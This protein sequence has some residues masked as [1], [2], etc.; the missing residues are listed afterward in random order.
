MPLFWDPICPPQ[1]I[2]SLKSYLDKRDYE[3][4]IVDFNTDGTL[5][6]L[7]K[8]YFE[9]AV[10]H[11][12][13]WKFLNIP[14]NGPRYFARHQLVWFYSRQKSAPYKALIRQI[15]NFDGKS[16]CTDQLIDALDSIIAE[17]FDIV[18]LKTKELINHIDPDIVG[19]TML[20]STFPSWHCYREHG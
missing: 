9:L 3:V 11:F 4:S 8:K 10:S 2:V 15:L 16:I 12:P 18:A 19:C 13:Q 14:R 1:G 17:I 7:Q 20:E 6:S 5:F